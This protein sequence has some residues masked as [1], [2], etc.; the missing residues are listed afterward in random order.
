MFDDL[1]FIDDRDCSNDCDRCPYAI[2][3]YDVP[4]DNEPELI[5]CKLED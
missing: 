4:F 5:G 1:D 3:N 2:I